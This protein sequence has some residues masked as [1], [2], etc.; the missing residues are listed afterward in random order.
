MSTN[1]VRT[2]TVANGLGIRK[3]AADLRCYALAALATCATETRSVVPD[4]SEF[5]FLQQH[6]EQVSRT[7]DWRDEFAA[8]LRDPN[9]VDIPL[10]DLATELGLHRLRRWQLLW[11][12]RSR[13]TPP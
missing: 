2:L 7:G 9:D 10:L 1:P 3:Q 12:L 8:Y 13:L 4:S 6:L 5:R 11:H